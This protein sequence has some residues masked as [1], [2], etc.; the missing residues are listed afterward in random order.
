M[1]RHTNMLFTDEW[2]SNYPKPDLDIAQCTKF[3]FNDPL[4]FNLPGSIFMRDIYGIS[5]IL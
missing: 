2:G 4:N 3:P 1:G 5:G